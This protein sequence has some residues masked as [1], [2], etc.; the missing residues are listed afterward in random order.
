MPGLLFCLRCLYVVSFEETKVRKTSGFM[1][2]FKHSLFPARTQKTFSAEFF[3]IKNKQK[4]SMAV[5][6]KN[7]KIKSYFIISDLRNYKRGKIKKRHGK[8]EKLNSYMILPHTHP[9]FYFH[10]IKIQTC[11]K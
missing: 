6:G 8:I 10:R 11:Q 7:K 2:C 3:K 1:M 4:Q 9:L 5:H